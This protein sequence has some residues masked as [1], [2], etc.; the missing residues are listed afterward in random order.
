MTVDG[1]GRVYLQKKGEKYEVFTLDW[2]ET[3]W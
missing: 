1:N 2:Q 3:L